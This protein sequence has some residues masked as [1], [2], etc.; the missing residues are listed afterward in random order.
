MKRRREGLPNGP[1]ANKTENKE[2]IFRKWAQIAD[3]VRVAKTQGIKHV[4]IS[5]IYHE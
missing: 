3:T 1:K 2:Q 5:P 4:Y